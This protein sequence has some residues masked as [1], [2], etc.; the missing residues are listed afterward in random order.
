MKVDIKNIYI[1][2]DNL[3]KK[4][5]HFVKQVYSCGLNPLL[6]NRLLSTKKKKHFHS[7][8]AVVKASPHGARLSQTDRFVHVCAHVQAGFLFAGPR[9]G[10]GGERA[11]KEGEGEGATCQ[12]SQKVCDS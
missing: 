3:C 11:G 12:R 10:E 9:V 4:R 6:F 1:F 8:A 5:Q 2:L 7:S